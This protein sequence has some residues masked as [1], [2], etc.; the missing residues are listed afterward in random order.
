MTLPE[1]INRFFRADFTAF[2]AD[3]ILQD[4]GATHRGPSEILAWWREAE[5][6]Y[7]HTVTPESLDG[8][9]VTAKVSGNFPGSPARIRSAFTLK[10]DRIAALE[11]G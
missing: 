8:T 9:T 6:R 2:D 5:A 4:E 11:I 3:A 1:P 10:N 7:Q